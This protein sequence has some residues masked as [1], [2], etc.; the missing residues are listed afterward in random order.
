MGELFI[1]NKLLS[2]VFNGFTTLTQ[3]KG[4]DKINKCLGKWPKPATGAQ[5]EPAQLAVPSSL[6]NFSNCMCCGIVQWYSAVVKYSGIGYIIITFVIG[7]VI[8]CMRGFYI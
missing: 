6:Y 2:H 8:S 1:M 7:C 5:S 4:L 3:E